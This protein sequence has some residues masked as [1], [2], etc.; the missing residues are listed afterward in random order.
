MQDTGRF[1]FLDGNHTL[2]R[3]A[4]H[5]KKSKNYFHDFSFCH[6]RMKK[7]MQDGAEYIFFPRAA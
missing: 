4:C 5:A 7:R 1:I 3:S 6:C 2:P